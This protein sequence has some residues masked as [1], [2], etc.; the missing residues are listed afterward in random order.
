[1]VNS[2]VSAEGF[3]GVDVTGGGFR[4]VVEFLRD[5]K[6]VR[7]FTATVVGTGFL[8]VVCFITV[9]EFFDGFERV[10][11][12]TGR[13][14]GLTV[15]EV[16]DSE[17]RLETGFFVA[18][19]VVVITGGFVFDVTFCDAV[20]FVTF[21]LIEFC[22]D[23]NVVNFILSVVLGGSVSSFNLIVF[24]TFFSI[25]FPSVVE[26][27][28]TFTAYFSVVLVVIFFVVIGLF[29]AAAVVVGINSNVLL[30]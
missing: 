2:C 15:A 6:V 14:V 22:I 26:K 18:A 3:V 8:V 21:C 12:T 28:P 20:L 4:L 25:I 29:D 1:M 30:L 23:W 17:V 7:R 24:V 10:D 27:P 11:D 9:V 16:D 13:R 5:V 19:V